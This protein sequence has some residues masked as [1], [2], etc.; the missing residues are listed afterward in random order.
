MLLGLGPVEFAALAQR[1]MTPRPTPVIM[2]DHLHAPRVS[3]REQATW[4]VDRLR[5]VRVTTFRA[6]TAD[7]TDT[8]TVVARFLALLELYRDDAVAF[9]QMDPLGELHVRWTVRTPATSTCPTSSTSPRP[10]TRTSR[11]SRTTPDD[12]NGLIDMTHARELD[13][14]RGPRRPG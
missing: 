14:H 5:R 6:L 10:A 4:L 12:S 7:C 2:L 8:L 13:R 9:D 1:V 3:V 11:T